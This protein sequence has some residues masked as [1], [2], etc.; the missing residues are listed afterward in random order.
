MAVDEVRPGYKRS[1]VGVIPENW[2]IRPLSELFELKNGVN[3]DIHDYGRGT[4]FANVLEV[5]TH[6]IC[7]WSKFRDES[8]CRTI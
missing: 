7:T 8:T 4:P 2:D 5:I 1:E 6:P 3:A